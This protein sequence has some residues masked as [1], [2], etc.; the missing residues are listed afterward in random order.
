M[1]VPHAGW[2]AYAGV[3]KVR[4][5]QGVFEGEAEGPGAGVHASARGG[6]LPRANASAKAGVGGVRGNV[7][8]ADGL[9]DIKGEAK[10]PDA[11][12]RASV[13]AGQENDLLPQARASA[14]CGVGKAGYSV[15]NG[16]YKAEYR[17]PNASARAGFGV[18]ET[19]AMAK[20]ELVGATGQVGPVVG[21][22][23]ISASTGA[24]F[25]TDGFEGKVLG[26]GVKCA[27]GEFSVSVFGSNLGF[28]F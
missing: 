14:Q 1:S 19:S 15:G 27:D 23:G 9:V 6:S 5:R 24:R 13:H 10:G 16:L 20:A 3:G 4:G 28:K 17:G 21:S 22:V 7:N 18:R 25:G 12:A 8:I 11:G 26:T 2:G